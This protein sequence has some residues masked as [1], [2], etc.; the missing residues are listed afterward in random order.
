MRVYRLATR[1]RLRMGLR[2]DRMRSAVVQ[3]GRSSG[4]LHAVEFVTA[5]VSAYC[6]ISE[7]EDTH[8]LH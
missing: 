5:C 8:I 4:L 3:L 2:P 7:Y 6:Y 1:M